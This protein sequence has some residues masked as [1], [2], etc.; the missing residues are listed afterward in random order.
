ML[1]TL[2]AATFLGTLVNYAVNVPLRSI[3]GYFHAPLS[4][5]V[6][7]V[8]SYVIVLAAGM[9]VSGWVGDRI[10]RKRVLVA[11]LALMS[12]A[13]VGAALAPSLPV[14][15]AMRAV[16][17]LACAAI[18]PTVMGVL[19]QV[20]P[21]GRGAR[22]MGAWAGANGVGQAVGP[23]FGGLIADLLGWR[24]IFWLLALLTVTVM[25]ASA[26]C[27]PGDHRRIAP[28]HWPGAVTLTLGSALLMTAATAVPEHIL[29]IWA[30]AA[31]AGV[32]TA[33][34]SA[35]AWVSVRADHPLVE[36]RLIVE[37]RFLRAT[38]AACAQMFALSTV[39]VA[40]PLYL[41]GE[42][43]R[44]TAVAGTLLFAL[45]AT[46]ALSAPFVGSLSDRT[47]PRLVLR[48]GLV[49][50]GVAVLL[51]SLFT[52][53][54]GR[55]LLTLA[56][57]L[58]AAGIGVALVQTPSAAGITRSP[59][60]RTGTALGLFNMMRFAG[61]A[62]GAAW[63]AIM[64]PRG[65]LFP[66][67]AGGAVLLAAGLAVSFAGPNPGKPGI[68]SRLTARSVS[69]SISSLCASHTSNRCSA[70]RRSRSST[71]DARSILY[72]MVL[73]WMCS[74]RAAAFR[75]PPDSI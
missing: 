5:A 70:W 39:A 61:S 11:A 40:V 43:G 54:G 2:L 23:P 72:S 18:P 8:S 50:L 31:A 22:A 36:P 29:P 16:Q 49:L 59:A 75:F 37:S 71:C 63:V 6:L 65:A 42:L 67:F 14:L 12:A 13:L 7:V 68:T 32:A 24:S 33:C 17:G 57:L 15:I 44:S 56:G 45:P 20:Y 73:R 51:L 48:V 52:E 21:A 62:F 66:L 25:A 1:S 69:K 4:A 74:S 41:T 27:L 38:I 47:S 58:V 3:A 19:S 28:L 34:L 9:T 10:G 46:M 35:F 60:G 64:Y 55:S 30:E 26:R 53:R